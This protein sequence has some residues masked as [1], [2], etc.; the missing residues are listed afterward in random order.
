M[1][2]LN[3][4][5]FATVAG[6]EKLDGSI[7]STDPAAKVGGRVDYRA[8]VDRFNFVVSGTDDSARDYESIPKIRDAVITIDTH[9]DDLS[10][11][12]GYDAGTQGFLASVGTSEGLTGTNL[13]VGGKDISARAWWFQK[14]NEVRTE[15]TINLDL[16]TK[17]WGAYTFNSVDNVANRTF[18]NIKEREGFII[19]P[20]TAS[21]AN[22]A[23]A[24]SHI[25]DDLTF[26]AAYDIDRNAAFLSVG[27]RQND[28]TAIKFGYAVKDEVALFEVAHRH[29]DDLPAIRLF[30]KASAGAG[31][32]GKASG[33]VI[34]DKYFD[35]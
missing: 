3:V 1:A 10:V 23:V 34:L 29:N 33:G 27:K 21:I 11:G 18:V 19:E 6:A 24:I 14:G 5:A 20:F 28:K 15:A 17:V 8:K 35:L 32:F 22:N 31:G 4:R 12:V 25:R 16:R 9:Q 26:D 7:G 30:A 2:N 13:R